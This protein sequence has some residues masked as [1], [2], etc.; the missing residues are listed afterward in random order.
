MSLTPAKIAKQEFAKKFRG[1]DP[2]EVKEFQETMAQLFQQVLTENNS[3]REKLQLY[4]KKVQEYQQ[5][6]KE[7]RNA[8][9]GAQRIADQIKEKSSQEAAA[10]LA[11]AR[12]DARQARESTEAEITN[13]RRELEE[14]VKATRESLGAQ[15]EQL[16]S[17]IKGL[18][19]IRTTVVAEMRAK[20]KAY[21]AAL[22]DD[23]PLAATAAIAEQGRQTTSVDDV[24]TEAEELQPPPPP[25]D[26]LPE[27]EAAE[28]EPAE[29]VEEGPVV[30]EVA[31]AQET[32]PEE[33]QSSVDLSDD[34]ANENEE[35][36]AAVAAAVAGPPDADAAQDEADT[37][38]GVVWN[39]PD[40]L[41][42]LSREVEDLSK[43]PEKAEQRGQSLFEA[44]EDTEED[45]MTATPAGILDEKKSAAGQGTADD[46]EELLPEEKGILEG[47]GDHGGDDLFAGLAPGGIGGEMSAAPPAGQDDAT[48]ATV[49][50]DSDAGENL[51]AGLEE[52][53]DA[54][55]EDEASPAVV[56]D[57]PSRDE[58]PAAEDLL[59]QEEGRPENAD[60]LEAMSLE[61][62][63]DT[64]KEVESLFKDE[65]D[66]FLGKEDK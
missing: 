35:T 40:N 8:V 48:P 49:E 41:A 36:E 13:I 54:G 33:E 45:D 22:D 9:L 30:A 26:A 16:A 59:Q 34:T 31:M 7:F 4:G 18:Q 60:E 6:E 3:L 51:F 19:E 29:E 63:E 55:P 62:D 2:D 57:L 42:E 61:L 44:E 21:L 17:E 10:T 23:A 53:G 52:T 15:Q 28:E 50:E 56:A 43:P 25:A 24:P 58:A 65:L 39:P 12:D 14:E 5:Q 38:R 46:D 20:L 37:S 66:D 1:Y 32:A 64:A 27:E 11:K 47:L